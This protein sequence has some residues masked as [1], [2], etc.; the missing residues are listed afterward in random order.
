[1]HVHTILWRRLDLPGH[2]ACRFLETADGFRVEGTAVFRE[3]DGPALLSY[4][5][6][7]DAD[8]HARTGRIRGWIGSQPIEREVARHDGNLWIL[9]RKPVAGLDDCLDLDLG[10]TPATNLFQLRRIALDVGDE[11]TFHV[12]WLDCSSKTIERV[13]Q[14]YR[15]LSL[16]SYSYESPR[17]GYS[18]ILLTNSDG[19][20]SNYPGLWVAES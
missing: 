11:A 18:A 12:A 8:W 2:D 6:E 3:G 9:D 7:C 19:H 14:R 15:R 16:D 10:F 20:V 4:E 1:M 5:V 17:F 13:E